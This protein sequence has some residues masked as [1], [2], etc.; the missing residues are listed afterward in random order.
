MQKNKKT[1]ILHLNI[2]TDK[3]LIFMSDIH[4]DIKLFKEALSKAQFGPDDILFVIGDMI[5][6]GDPLDNL[7]MLKYIIELNKQENVYFMAGNCDEVFR[8]ILPP[9]D[10]KRF[11]YYATELKKS[12]INDMA[13]ELSYPIS[14]DMDI[15]HYIH[16]IEEQYPEFF[17][18]VDNLPDVIF[19]NDS[20][21]LV[22]GGIM[23]I[24][25]IP[26]NSL[27]VLKCDHFLEYSPVQ[28]KIMLVGHNPTRNYRTDIPC[29]NP[30][31]DYRKNIICLDGGNNVV[32][33]GQIN[34]VSLN[35]L[36]DMSFSFFAIDHYPKYIVEEDIRY[37]Q[38]R[39]QFTIRFGKNEVEILAKDLDFY[40][41]RPKG[42][43]D[44]LWVHEEFIVKSEE[45]YYCYDGSNTF[46]NLKKGDQISVI[47]KAKPYSLIK[48]DGVVGLIES[49]YIH[50]NK[51]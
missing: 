28:P 48:H 8:F 23:D 7:A 47:K 50:D 37:E 32:K 27:E 15:E 42:T 6:K 49:K 9:L 21:V 46:L 36:S 24:H 4:G 17:D 16:T 41:I 19:I 34:V 5:E 45:K 29:V 51:L 43:S 40:L 25:Q 12:V 35:N 3:R 11:L 22:H 38:P 10:K 18:F 44:E 14:K 31:F 33:G 2:P 26:E 13:Y 1:K 20:L 30:I 39:N